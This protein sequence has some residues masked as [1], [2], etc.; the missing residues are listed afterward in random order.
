MGEVYRARDTKL[1]REVAIKI[2]PEEF[3]RDPDRVAQKVKPAAPD[4]VCE[5]LPARSTFVEFG[6]TRFF[7]LR[8]SRDARHGQLEQA[9]TTHATRVKRWRATSPWV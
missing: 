7:R 8:L 5:E 6:T 4:N 9:G 1:K 2:L 3:S